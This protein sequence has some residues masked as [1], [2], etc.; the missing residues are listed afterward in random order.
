MQSILDEIIPVQAQCWWRDDIDRRLERSPTLQWRYPDILTG[1]DLFT[2]ILSNVLSEDRERRDSALRAYLTSQF[3]IDEEVRF[4]QVELQNKLFDLFID[5]PISVSGVPAGSGGKFLDELIVEQLSEGDEDEELEAMLA[6][7]RRSTRVLPRHLASNIGAASFLLQSHVGS[8][9]RRL[10]LEGAPG[11]GKSTIAQYICQIHRIQLLNKGEEF[12][13]VPANHLTSPIRLPMKVDLRDLAVWLEG[14]DPFSVHSEERPSQWRPSLEAFLAAQ[15]SHFAGGPQFSVSDLH[16]VARVSH[17][18]IALDGFDEVADVESRR[19]VVDAIVKAT[20]RL[21]ELAPSVQ[22]VV[23]SRPAAFANSPGFPSKTFPHFE[24]DSVTREQ[25]VQYAMRWARARGLT[26]SERTEFIDTLKGKLEEPHLRELARNPMQLAILL[27]LILTKG[28]SLPD[29]RTA[30]YDSYIEVFFGREAEKSVI[31]RE[32]RELLIDIHR[33]LAWKM[34]VH[35]EE[36]ASRGIITREQLES[37][38][39]DYLKSEGHDTC[40]VGELFTGMVERVVAL[41]SRV[42]GTFEFE[43]QPLREYFAARHLYETA[44]YSPPGG[45]RTG[46]KPERFDVIARNFYWLNV[47]RFY[48][49]CFS[50]GE[51]AALVDSLEELMESDGYRHI[52]YPRGLCTMLLGDWVFSQQ[53]KIVAEVVDLMADGSGIR[54]QLAS[55]RHAHTREFI[56]L[57]EKCGKRALIDKCFDELRRAKHN[58]YRS[59][60]CAIVNSNASSNEKAELWLESWKDL[61]MEEREGWLRCGS[62]LRVFSAE[63]P[64]VGEIWP[65]LE[66]DRRS[67]RHIIRGGGG[68]YFERDADIFAPAVEVALQ[69]G[70]IAFEPYFEMHQDDILSML[71]LRLD[72]RMYA[73][74][75]HERAKSSPMMKALEEFYGVDF[76]A[77]PSE[78]KYQHLGEPGRHAILILETIKEQVQRPLSEWRSSLEPWSRIV[79]AAA[80]PG[81]TIYWRVVYFGM[82]AA[83]V[84]APSRS[85]RKTSTHPLDEDA[86]LCERIQAARGQR[87]V[88]WWQEYLLVDDLFRVK[89]ALAV[90]LAWASPRVLRTLEGILDEMI[91]GLSGEDWRDVYNALTLAV[92]ARQSSPSGF[93]ADWLSTGVSPRL[94]IAC[95]TRSGKAEAQKIY[96]KMLIDYGGDDRIVW[97]CCLE[98]ALQGAQRDA[99]TWAHALRVVRQSYSNG[100]VSYPDIYVHLHY[101]IAEGDSPLPAEVAAQI[102]ASPTQYPLFMLGAAEVRRAAE[103]RGQVRPVGQVAREN[104]WF[105]SG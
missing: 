78:D 43:V 95:A 98:W 53:P 7:G 71:K 67:W 59:G 101:G 94:A 11:Q 88:G 25:A 20:E 105:A 14:R 5:V 15:I 10:V 23:T 33:Y 60:L 80:G 81:R 72:R 36:L 41:V 68:R 29:K 65:T 77:I 79:E 9:L 87:G 2:A 19:Q 56:L 83:G 74:S 75:R 8:R 96:N 82:F 35:A 100:A 26:E 1:R 13:R 90:T 47:T 32:H 3:K 70:N 48:A 30:M 18:L 55:H 73:M 61:L 24:L 93:K 17:L 84:V 99:E 12:G 89:L 45:E 86:P 40:L 51:L 4:K 91:S 42:E 54:L 85:E 28:A 34:H 97:N 58:D 49:G 64:L 66:E 22:V 44:P 21:E 76:N 103:V 46:T 31:V 92:S 50:R 104:A 57:P 69:D 37:I 39:L 102:C 52:S 16:A 63:T 6:Y 27:S 62:R 38:L